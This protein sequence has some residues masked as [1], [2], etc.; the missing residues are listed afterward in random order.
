MEPNPH[1]R[2]SKISVWLSQ[3]AFLAA[4]VLLVA[5]DQWTKSAVSAYF[6]RGGRIRQIPVLGGLLHL[7]YT[8]NTGGA[9]GIFAGDSVSVALVAVSLFALAFI[10]WY[11]WQ[12]RHSLWMRTALTLVA[13]GAVGNFIDRARLR[14]VVD[15]IDVDIGAYQWPYFNIADSLICV[16]AGLL[17]LYLLRAKNPVSEAERVDDAT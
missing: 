13:S 6:Q 5:F 4:A 12:Y 15:F 11:Y 9:F 16:G 1:D 14:Y 10:F 2:S 8:E 7:T 3:I 17:I